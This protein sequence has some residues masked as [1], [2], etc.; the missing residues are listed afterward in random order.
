MGETFAL[1]GKL[2]DGATGGITYA[3]TDAAIASVGS[4]GLVTAVAPG[5]VTVTA[6]AEGGAYAECF[7]TVKQA[8]DAVSFSSAKFTIGKG[9]STAALKVVLGS[10]PGQCAGSYTITSS[11]K[12]IVSVKDGGV[13][14]GLKTGK[15]V[16]TVTTYNGL[17]AKCN[18]TVVKA[19]KKVVCQVDKQMMG[20]GET[21]Q[22][23]T[24]CPSGRPARSPSP[25]RTPPWWPWMPPA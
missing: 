13:I 19:P 12:K 3:S 17:T 2:P 8:P 4:D 16:L 21:G 11:K 15:A 14:A 22:T 9:E 7:V 23:A 10:T 18:V 24:P 25:A 1:A 5:D 20:I 6:T